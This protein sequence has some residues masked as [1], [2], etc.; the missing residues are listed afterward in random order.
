MEQAAQ[1]FGV[2]KQTIYNW[3]K[4]LLPHETRNKPATKID[5]QALLKDVKKYPDAYQFERAKRLDVSVRCV[6]YALKRLGVS[7]KKNSQPSPGLRSK[8]AYISG[9][10]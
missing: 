5:M 2:G 10:D 1:R 9:K 8:T 3:T 6:G 7:Y 4:R